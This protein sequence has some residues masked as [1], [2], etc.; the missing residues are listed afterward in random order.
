MNCYYGTRS[1]KMA[2]KNKG[3]TRNICRKIADR[4]KACTLEKHFCGSY[5]IFKLRI[6]KTG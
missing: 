5:I 6:R 4:N 1:G 3:L 2:Q